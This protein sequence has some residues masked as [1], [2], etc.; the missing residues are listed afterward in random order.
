VC[1]ASIKPDTPGPANASVLN[2]QILC[3]MLRD[4]DSGIGTL[5]TQ[6]KRRPNN[7]TIVIMVGDNGGQTGTG[8]SNFPLRGNKAT[9]MQ[10]GLL[11]PAWMYWQGTGILPDSLRGTV[12]DNFYHVTDLLPT[13]ARLAGAPLTDG[14]RPEETS[15]GAF[16]D[17]GVLEAI[18]SGRA[19]DASS[20]SSSASSSTSSLDKE[21]NADVVS[22]SGS[23]S[24]SL[25]LPGYGQYS[26]ITAERARRLLADAEAGLLVP[27]V[28]MQAI[29]GHDI[30]ESVMNPGNRSM[31]PRKSIVIQVYPARASA[32]IVGGG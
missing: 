26:S 7:R 21:I 32:Q 19:V 10:G 23:L 8:G 13:L 6:L 17:R 9:M 24:S 5:M 22:G 20:S 16:A 18:A 2:R 31:N 14:L 12:N 27:G 3:G 15:D 11:V 1:N 28:T 4:A 30:W 25:P 29:D